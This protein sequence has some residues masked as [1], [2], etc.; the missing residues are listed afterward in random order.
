MTIKE[1]YNIFLQHPSVETDTRKIKGGEIFF[2]LKGPNFNGNKYVQNAFDAG[3]AFCICDETN[4][5]QDARI[6]Y[7]EDVLNSLQE[8]AKYHRQQFKIPFIAITGSNGKTTTKELVYEVLRSSFKCYTTKGNLNNHIGVPLTI[9]S[10]KKDAEIAVIEMGANHQKEIEGYCL[11]TLPTHGLIT[12][13]G[14]AHLEGFGGE[15]GVKKGKGELYNYLA[16]TNGTIFIN[17]DYD[18][19]QQMSIDIKNKITYGTVQATYTGVAL[20]NKDLLEVK[21]T[22]GATIKIIKTQLVGNYNL[23]NVMSAVC[24]GKYFGVTDHKIKTALEAYVPTNSRSQIIKEGTNTIILDAYNANPSSMKAAIENFASMKEK[25]NKKIVIL[26]AMMELGN[27]SIAEHKTIIELLCQF[28]W[29][30]VAVAGEDYK[31][32]P[33]SILHF[34]DA[35]ETAQ[36]FKQQQFENAT[37]LIKGSRGMAMEKVLE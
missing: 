14:K 33:A 19:L 37:I 36:W 10:V 27:E 29:D 31:N 34:K 32:L 21:I 23:P 13:C 1:L 22:T 30:K 2:A 11:Y 4:G 6:I 8:L 25:G 20:E 17:T 26:G 35:A 28:K 15:N 24:I 7:V 5:I 12:N 3:A 18:Y 16:K 9:L